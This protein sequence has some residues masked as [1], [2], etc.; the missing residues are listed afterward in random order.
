VSYTIAL[1]HSPS[2][3]R[4]LTLCVLHSCTIALLHSPSLSHSHSSMSSTQP[5]PRLHRGAGHTALGL[6]F[7]LQRRD[8]MLS[9]SPLPGTK[10]WGYHT[11]CKHTIVCCRTPLYLP[12]SLQHGEMS[13]I[14]KL[15]I[16]EC[17][18]VSRQR[19]KRETEKKER[20]RICSLYRPCAFGCSQQYLG[21][22]EEAASPTLGAFVISKR[23]KVIFLPPF[24][25]PC[26][27]V[28]LTSVD[29][30]HLFTQRR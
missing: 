10:R 8:C 5:E 29:I 26:R 25:R 4:S 9:H 7:R 17:M 19:E 11:D 3:P 30:L 24:P 22:S 16:S 12:A 6:P 20:E 27:R 2:L 28:H 21:G 1:L 14:K 13:T 23:V 15:Y 18:Y